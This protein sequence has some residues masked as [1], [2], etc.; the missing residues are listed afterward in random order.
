MNVRM[1]TVVMGW[2]S[3]M[4]F[5]LIVVV[6]K[7]RNVLGEISSHFLRSF[8]H[9]LKDLVRAVER[10]YRDSGWEQKPVMCLVLE[11]MT[12]VEGKN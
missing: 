9:S 12:A 11:L 4:G 8:F 7:K 5:Q 3:I 1:V 2:F 10:I 6:H